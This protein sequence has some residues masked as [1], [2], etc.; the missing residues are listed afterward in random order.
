I[1]GPDP[2]SAALSRA[3]DPQRLAA[4]A[5][6]AGGAASEML[7]QFPAP[8]HVARRS[9]AELIKSWERL[10][11][12]RAPEELLRQL[13]LAIRIWQPSVVVTDPDDEHPGRLAS[14]MLV[15]QAVRASFKRAADPRAFPEQVEKLGL[16]PW[17]ATKLYARVETK[18]KAE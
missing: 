12:D 11:A 18:D 3:S 7:W 8:Q 13:V 2:K 17:Q 4:A 9:T 5:R 1:V 15:G 6:Q 14:D 10:P 16:Q